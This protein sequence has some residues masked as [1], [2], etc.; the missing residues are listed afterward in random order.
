[1][2]EEL[3]HT[4]PGVAE[5]GR[6]GVRQKSVHKVSLLSGE[7]LVY[8]MHGCSLQK[9]Y[10]IRHTICQGTTIFYKTVGNIW[11]ARDFHSLA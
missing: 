5:V 8:S 4:L 11:K 3:A 2:R 1:M 10:S 7:N 9:G 6:K